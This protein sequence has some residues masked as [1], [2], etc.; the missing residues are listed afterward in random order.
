MGHPGG[1]KTNDLCGTMLILSPSVLLNRTHS[2]VFGES[3]CLQG[4]EGSHGGG[5]GGSQ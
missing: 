5:G 3:V 4:W 1:R 2:E